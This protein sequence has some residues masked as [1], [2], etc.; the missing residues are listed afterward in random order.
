M[1][2]GCKVTI[3][4]EAPGLTT[5]VTGYL[6]SVSYD[7]DDYRYRPPGG[8]LGSWMQ[9]SPVYEIQVEHQ[10][11]DL[12]PKQEE[13]PVME[14]PSITAVYNER[15]RRVDFFKEV[16]P[17]EF[18]GL[19]GD[20]IARVPGEEMPL[21]REIPIEELGPMLNAARRSPAYDADRGVFRER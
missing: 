4:N 18:E 9:S 14:Y 1:K 3:R 21:W 15:S 19:D 8:R 20:I 7:D 10:A 2:P 6:K 17:N 16:E 5:V 12:K 11:L 13:E